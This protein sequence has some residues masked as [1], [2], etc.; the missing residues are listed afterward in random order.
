MPIVGCYVRVESRDYLDLWCCVSIS[1]EL[2]QEGSPSPSPSPSASAQSQERWQLSAELSLSLSLTPIP[3]DRLTGLECDE[4]KR[5][6]KPGGPGGPG[7]PLYDTLSEI[8]SGWR[9][10]NISRSADFSDKTFFLM[11]PKV[12]RANMARDQRK[13]ARRMPRMTAGMNM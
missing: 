4:D 9:E 5:E 10:G 7:G 2:W 8:L 1:L 3:L 13:T 11:R 12:L 6:L